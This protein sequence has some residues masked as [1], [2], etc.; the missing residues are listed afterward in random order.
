VASDSFVHLHVHSEY[1]MLDGAAKIGAM[2]QA[3]AEYDMPAIAVTDHGNTFAAFEFYNAARA[4][5]VKPIIGLEAYVTPGTHRSDK[6]RVSWGSPDQKSDDVSGSGAYTHMTMWSESTEGMHNLFRLSSLSSMEGYYFKPRMDRELLQ[7]YGKGLI[8]TTGCPS[9]EVQTRL[10]LGQYDAARAAAAE[11]QDI[12]GKDNYFAEIMDHGLSIERRVMSDLIRLSKDLGIPLVATND[13]HYTHRH[14]A[15]AHEALLCVQSGSTLDDPNRFKFDGDGY[16]IKTA[17]EMRQMFREHPEACDNTLLI[18]ERCEVEFNTSANYMPRFPVPDGETEDSWLIKEVEAG[19]H[20]R[21]P[22]GIPDRV[23]KQAEYETGIILQ[24]GFPGYFLVVADFINWAK[25]NGIRVG[26]GRGSG[27]GSMVAYAM[28]ITD[29]DP[30]EHGLIFERFLNPDRVSM[31][32]FDVDF[33]DRRRGEVIDY[34]TAKYG[35]ERV[36]QIVTYGT[37]KSKQALKDAGRVLGF[38]FSMG[39]KLTKAMPPAVMGKDM[40]LDGMF[41]P[42]HQR[43]K[44]ASEFRALI[45]SDPEAKTVFDRALGLEG[46]KRQWGVHAAG[47]IMSSEPLLDIIPIMRREQ[48]GQIVTQFDYP[49]CEAL[50]LIKMDFLGLRNLTIISDALENIRSNRGEELDLEH[51]ALDDRPAYDL[52]SRGDTLGVFQLDGGPMRALL[53]LMRPDNFEDISAVIALYRPGPMGANSHTNYALRKNGQQPITPIHPELE[54][55]LRD[56]LDTTY[57]L[58]IYQEQVMAIAQ[59][60][61]GFSLGQADILRRAMGKKK[62]SELDKQYE[63]FSGG[64]KERGFGDGAIQALWDILLPFSDYAFNKAHSAAYGLVSYWTAYLK[65]HYPAEYMAALLTSVGD[66]KDKMAVYLN[67]CRRMG[68]RVLPPDV[69]ESIRYFAAVGEDIRFG[70]GAVR[71]VGSNVVDGIV[72]SRSEEG[73]ASFHDFLAKVPIHVANKRTVESLIK[74]GAFDSMGDTRRALL[75]IHEDAVEAAVDRKRNEAQGAIGFDFDSLYDAAE[76]VVPPKVPP[77]PEWTKKD[78]LGFEREMLGLYVSDHPLAGLEIPLAKH[79]STSIHDLLVSDDVSDGDIVTVAGLVTSV[80]HRVA[81]QSGNPYGMITIEDF[82]GEVTVMFMGKTYTEFQAMLQSDAILVVRGRV[83]RRDDGLNLHGQSAFTPD[84][85]SVDGSG[86]LVLVMPEHRATETTIGELSAV[87][88]RHRGDTEVTL[89]L[90]KGGAAKVFE[91]PARV[92]ISVD[93]YGELKG[94]LG[95]QCLG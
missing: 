21:Y 90:H 8:A 92:A 86:P 50:G 19:L 17:A 33:D 77:R 79:A 71:N 83:S 89:K 54:E 68:I 46:L 38:P 57:G 12:F 51:L 32:D 62:K 63:G 13:S 53:R 3:A 5:G 6:S 45:E 29:L 82:D 34:V 64:M 65:A 14:E 88:G 91:V 39:E 73:F 9:G 81:K 7:T 67:E 24:M 43:Y 25:D 2:T 93:L 1:S 75:E 85:G 37:I 20:Y 84:L 16:Y 10:R 49:S 23:R 4:A 41:N 69:G 26:P 55:P 76:E 36:A 87:F 58:I 28:K 72:A 31:P 15:D 78:K 42:T 80:Q 11:F 60:V 48:D 95:P 40:P 22:D 59:K 44:E 66:S 52:L 94:L 18:A 56:I 61:A 35:S 74:A 47:V 30:L 27:A 70:L